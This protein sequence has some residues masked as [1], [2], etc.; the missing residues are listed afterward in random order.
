MATTSFSINFDYRCPFARNANEH[1]VTALR[2]GADYDVSFKGFSLTQIYVE[3]GGVPAWEDPDK[4]DEMIAVAAGIVVRERFPDL[5]LAAHLSLFALRH[6][7]AEDLRDEAQLR[8]ALTR[9]GVDADEVFREVANGWPLEMLGKEHL[10]AVDAYQAFGV[11]TF[12]SGDDAVFVR[13]MTRPNG[14]AEVATATVNRVLDLLTA[15]P[16]INEYKHTSVPM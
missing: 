13:L 6:D 15:H 10:E 9:A 2:A 5:F 16:E 1:V 4:Y 8:K 12:I 14:D 11:P 7:D 3:E